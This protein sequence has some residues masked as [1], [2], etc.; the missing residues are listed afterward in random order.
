[1]SFIVMLFLAMF[2]ANLKGMCEEYI[3]IQTI[4]QREYTYKYVSGYHAP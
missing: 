1:M 3:R 4:Q 2:V